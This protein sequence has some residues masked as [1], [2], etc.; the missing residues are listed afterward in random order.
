[1]SLMQMKVDEGALIESNGMTKAST[2]AHKVKN[3]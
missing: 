2:V 1:M 3:N